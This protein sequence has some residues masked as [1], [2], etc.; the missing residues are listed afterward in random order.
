[1]NMHRRVVLLLIKALFPSKHDGIDLIWHHRGDTGCAHD[2]HAP[3]SIALKR[4]ETYPQTVTWVQLSIGQNRNMGGTLT[5][6]R[7]RFNTS[8]RLSDQKA[9]G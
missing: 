5:A 7:L 1:M 8:F 6:H 9:S 4:P 3:I 2:M